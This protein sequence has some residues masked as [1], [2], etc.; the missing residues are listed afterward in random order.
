MTSL[1]L[2]LYLFSRE[3][4]NIPLTSLHIDIQY[5]MKATVHGEIAAVPWK[6]SLMRQS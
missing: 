6:K 5:S 4:L 2:K 3:G 1:T